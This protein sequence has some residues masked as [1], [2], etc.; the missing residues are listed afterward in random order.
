MICPSRECSLAFQFRGPGP[1]ESWVP[2]VSLRGPAQPQAF[3]LG[4]ELAPPLAYASYRATGWHGFQC[5]GIHEA[6]ASLG[7]G[8]A[9][10]GRSV[11]E[12]GEAWVSMNPDTEAQG[13]VDSPAPVLSSHWDV[14]WDG[15]H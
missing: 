3:I 11:Q 13:T 15:L 4:P 1:R 5:N 7:L 9:V 14:C 8:K 10:W 2:L 6:Q 12:L